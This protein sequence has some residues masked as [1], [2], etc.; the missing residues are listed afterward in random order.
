MRGVDIYEDNKS[1]TKHEDLLTSCQ[2][3]VLKIAKSYKKKL[4]SHI[5]LS[6]LI[7]SGYVGLL[8]ASRTYKPDQGASFETYASCRIKGSIIDEMRKNSWGT[9]EGLKMMRQLSDAINYLEQHLGRQPNSDEIAEHLN[10]TIDD[11]FEMCDKVNICQVS[12]MSELGDVFAVDESAI[13][14]DQQLEA[15]GVKATIKSELE[16]LNERDKVLLSLYYNDE[17]TF[18]EIAEILDLTEAR[19]CQL[20]ANAIVKLRSKID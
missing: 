5:E 7:Q 9:R 6:D 12:S 14:P 10:I 2:D 15:D 16:K 8:E 17:M 4:P 20:H 13:N 11:Y 19:I 3:L 1:T 18:K